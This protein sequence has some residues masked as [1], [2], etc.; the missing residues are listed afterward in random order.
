MP[1]QCHRERI[2]NRADNHLVR[3][4][5]PVELKRRAKNFVS[6]RH[7]HVRD[8]PLVAAMCHRDGRGEYA[9]VFKP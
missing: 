2:A 5:V 8:R 9:V 4:G 1:V 7:G 3:L 6:F